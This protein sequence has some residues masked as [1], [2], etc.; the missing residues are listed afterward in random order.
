MDYDLDFKV[1][2]GGLIIIDFCQKVNLIQT[3]IEEQQDFER[4][5]WFITNQ[6]HYL[7]KFN[8]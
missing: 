6:N 4:I 8:S 2:L 7:K 5:S 1:N 3:E